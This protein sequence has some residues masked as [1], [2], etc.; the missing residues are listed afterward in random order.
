MPG[1]LKIGE[2]HTIGKTPYDRAEELNTTG[3]P[4]PFNVEFYASTNDSKKLETDIHILLKE[5]RN[6]E[7]REFFKIT[8]DEAKALF[9][10]H[11]PYITW[12]NEILSSTSSKNKSQYNTL[13]DKYDL[14]KQY[15]NSY[16]K[17]I[18]NSPQYNGFYGYRINRRRDEIL[19]RLKYIEEGL[20]TYKYNKEE[21]IIMDKKE[22]QNDNRYIKNE[23][24][25]IL[26]DLDK[27]KLFMSDRS[28]E[29][30]KFMRELSSAGQ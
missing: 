5:Y 18:K 15:V 21:G 28:S 6:S 1:L 29:D 19:Q 26:K 9:E 25:N 8:L 17:S 16:F 7:S 2:T 30:I 12:T 10:E 13:K 23:L 4:T 22:Q 27:F 20:N 11:I 14:V 24:N 3:V